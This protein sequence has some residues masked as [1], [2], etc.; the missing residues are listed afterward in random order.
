MNKEE[1]KIFQSSLLKEKYFHFV[2][3]SGLPVYLCPKNFSTS[4]A[5]FATSYGSLDNAFALEDED[6]QK[7]PEGIA[8]FLEHK[9]FDCKDGMDASSKLAAIG[10]YANAFTS[11]DKTG[12]IFSC[13]ENEHE[14]LEILLDFVTEP[15]FTESSVKKEQGIIAQE[16]RM[17]ED[18]PGSRLYC[19]MLRA[20]YEKHPVREEIAGSVDSIM[21]IDADLLYKCHRSFYNLNNMGLFL[22]GNFDPEKVRDICDKVLKRSDKFNIKRP[23]IKEGPAA[24]RS[25]FSAKM[26]VSKP[27]F[28]IGVKD[29]DI[30]DD[31]E[32]RTKKSAA[33]EILCEILFSKSSPFFSELYENGLISGDLEYWY[34]HNKSFS[35]ISIGGEADDPEKVYMLFQKFIRNSQKEGINKEDFERCKRVAYS[36]AVKAFDNTEG[37][38]NILLNSVFAGEDPFSYADAVA[39]TEVAYLEFLLRSMFKP[40]YY[41]LAKIMPLKEDC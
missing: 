16:I 22:C 15:Y 37:I 39:K 24:Y 29:I 13:T 26:E 34:E 12:Y 10:A 6:V 9:L 2:H 3:K 31:P 8:H 35:L 17:Y 23:E 14:A 27:L 33:L 18:S 38:G 36:T 28:S 20:L 5:V 11:Y 30:S 7:V 25:E 41:T 1:I 40:E 19:G 32:E 21:E 4:Y